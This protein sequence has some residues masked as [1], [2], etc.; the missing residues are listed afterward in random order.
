M[1]TFALRMKN[2]KKFDVISIS[3]TIVYR[4]SLN[5]NNEFE[6]HQSPCYDK[7]LKTVPVNHQKRH[8]R[9]LVNETGGMASRLHT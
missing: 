8:G 2:N 5:E 9:F 4:N 3:Q 7:T 1:I 6:L